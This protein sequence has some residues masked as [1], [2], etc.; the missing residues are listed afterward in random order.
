M[1]HE[2]VMFPNMCAHAEAPTEEDI[3]PT[4]EQAEMPESEP[5]QTPTRTAR[6]TPGPQLISP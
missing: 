1:S 5:T 6:A 3:A 2:H 4:P